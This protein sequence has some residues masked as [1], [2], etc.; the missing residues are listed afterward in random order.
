MIYSLA[1]VTK[2]NGIDFVFITVPNSF[3]KVQFGLRVPV[4]YFFF[5]T[6]FALGRGQLLLF[7]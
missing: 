1:A 6:C 2:C 7:I 3:I 5:F 4:F